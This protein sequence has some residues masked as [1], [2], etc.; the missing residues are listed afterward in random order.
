VPTTPRELGPPRIDVTKAL[1][2]AGELE[3]EALTRRLARGTEAVGLAWIAL[4]AFVRIGTNASILPAPMTA[5]EATGQLETW[6][7]APPRL[8]PSPPRGT[9]ACSVDSCGTPAQPAI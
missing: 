5:D 4:L 8:S 7:G 6:L 3:D 2:L 9:P 1:S